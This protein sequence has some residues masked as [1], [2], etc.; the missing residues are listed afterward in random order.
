MKHRVVI[1]VHME[2]EEVDQGYASTEAEQRL[3]G[4]RDVKRVIVQKCLKQC[5][6]S[7]D[8]NYGVTPPR[9]PAPVK[10]EPVRRDPGISFTMVGGE[11]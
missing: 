4:V 7:E 3:L 6:G 9:V 2:I 8:S 1:E 10:A 5:T 11:K